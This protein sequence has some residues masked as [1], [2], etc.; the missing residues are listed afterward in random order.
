MY[1]R[2]P[3]DHARDRQDK[4]E[5]PYQ[6]AKAEM[7]EADAILARV[8]PPDQELDETESAEQRTARQ[9]AEASERLERIGEEIE[10]SVESDQVRQPAKTP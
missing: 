6:D 4:G 3:L 10:R 8:A 9:E 7:S 2:N 5:Q 1:Q